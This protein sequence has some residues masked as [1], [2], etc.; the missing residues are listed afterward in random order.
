MKILGLALVSFLLAWNLTG[1]KPAVPA[2]GLELILTAKG[3]DGTAL[4]A[5]EF[6]RVASVLAQRV[7][8]LGFPSSYLRVESD[9]FR[10]KFDPV[11]KEEIETVRMA[12]TRNGVLQFRLVHPEGE[13]LLV[14][15]IIPGDYEV[16]NEMRLGPGGRLDRR[17]LVSRKV[18]AGLDNQNLARVA[19]GRGAVN[20]L[21]IMFQLDTGGK[22]V[23]AQLTGENVGRALAIVIDG[24]LYSAPVI[25]TPITE[26]S[27]SISGVF[28]QTEASVLAIILKHAQGAKVEIMEERRF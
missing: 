14:D 16:L 22:A 1:C 28:S 17:H 12:M 7:D 27:A 15:G 9:T 25:R 8:A 18:V 21:E 20:Q 5:D 3:V 4:K 10:L 11:S 2:H 6:Q 23:F 19:V 26:G 13:R 24:Q